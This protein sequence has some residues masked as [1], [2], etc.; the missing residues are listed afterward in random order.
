[1]LFDLD[2]RGAVTDGL[3]EKSMVTL[4][5]QIVY[6]SGTLYGSATTCQRVLLLKILF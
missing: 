5:E 3:S 4:R 6:H 2:G 1:M